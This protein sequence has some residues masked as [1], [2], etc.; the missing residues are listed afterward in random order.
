MDNAYPR[1]VREEGNRKAQEMLREVFEPCD[2]S[3]RGLGVI[4]KSGLRLGEGYRDFAAS[5]RFDL[6]V[7]PTEEPRGCACGDVIRGKIHPGACMLFGDRCTP[8]DPVG[9]CMVSSEG[10]CAAYYRY[11]VR[12]GERNS[13]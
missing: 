13:G 4:P 2:A 12:K 6:Q 7:P 11:G 5:R 8:S 10:A 9:P 1:A 3:W